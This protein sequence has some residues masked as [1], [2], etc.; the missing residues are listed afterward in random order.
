MPSDSLYENYR[1]VKLLVNVGVN[2][3]VKLSLWLFLKTG[4]WY[5]HLKRRKTDRGG[6]C[7][8]MNFKAY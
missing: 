5:F 7:I 8:M 4:W 3:K 6:N 2:V 1:L